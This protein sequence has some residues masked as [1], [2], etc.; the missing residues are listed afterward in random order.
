MFKECN[1]EL[2][3]NFIDYGA[4]AIVVNLTSIQNWIAKCLQKFLDDEA[5][6]K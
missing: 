2:A 3:A 4:K 1:T 6:A 5:V